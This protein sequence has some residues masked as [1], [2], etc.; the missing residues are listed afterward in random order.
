MCPSL[1]KPHLW[2]IANAYLQT[3]AT[4]QLYTVNKLNLVSRRRI[5]WSSRTP[6]VIHFLWKMAE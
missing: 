2:C 5:N 3:L 1:G 4:L 6:N